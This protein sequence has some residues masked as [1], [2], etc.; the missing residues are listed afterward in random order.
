MFFC[1]GGAD[2]QYVSS[3]YLTTS[4]LS[5]W[6]CLILHSHNIF[7]ISIPAMSAAC[8]RNCCPPTSVPLYHT[9]LTPTLPHF[10][11]YSFHWMTQEQIFLAFKY[12]ACAVGQLLIKPHSTFI[13]SHF[14]SCILSC[15]L[16]AFSVEFLPPKLFCPSGLSLLRVYGSF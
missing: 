7:R 16:F 11:P 2:V 12:N 9:I 14:R 1:R 10:T 8:Y 5:S 4:L 3:R 6:I 15:R 13:L